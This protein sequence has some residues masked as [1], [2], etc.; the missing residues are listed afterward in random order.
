MG[1]RLILMYPI[2]HILFL[3]K[4]MSI[5]TTHLNAFRIQNI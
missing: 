1:Y 3:L 4:Q 2:W 5:C